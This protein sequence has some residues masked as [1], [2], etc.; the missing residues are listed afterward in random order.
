MHRL[1]QPVDLLGGQ[2][3]SLGPVGGV[4]ADIDHTDAV[5]IRFRTAHPAFI[6]EAEMSGSDSQ[7]RLTRTAG[8]HRA[9]P[10][11]DLAAGTAT[12]TWTSPDGTRSAPL[13][14]LP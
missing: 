1:H 11:A 7:L 6:G 4:G 12:V 10:E 8:E 14:E 9:D 13:A 3:S 2:Q 5:M